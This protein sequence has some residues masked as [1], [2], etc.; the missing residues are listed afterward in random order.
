MSVAQ[1]LRD[2]FAPSILTGVVGYVGARYIFNLNN[3]NVPTPIGDSNGAVVAGVGA[4]MGHLAGEVSKDTVLSYLPNNEYVN[5]ESRLVSP[6]LAGLGTY[7]VFRLGV[8]ENTEFINS[9]ALGA[10][11][12]VAG[13]YSWDLIQNR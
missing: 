5:A 10:G 9:F 2:E 3:F 4:M 6:A 7:A 8:S 12:S 1:K 11:S 13:K